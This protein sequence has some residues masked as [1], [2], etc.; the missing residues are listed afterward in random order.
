MRAYADQMVH[1]RKA[2]ANTQSRNDMLDAMLHGTDPDT[3]EKLT[4]ANLVAYAIYFLAKNPEAATKA[5]EEINAVV[6]DEAFA[7][8]HLKQLHYVEACLRESI[9]LSATAPGFNIEPIPSGSDDHT[10]VL[11]AGGEYQIPHNQTI[12]AILHT[13]NRDPAVFEYP[14]DFRPEQVLGEK[15]DNLPAA[16]QKGFG[17]GKRECIGKAWAWQ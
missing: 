12:I 3:A 2:N 10:P 1:N 13:V 8:H 7:L 6:G 15:W 17:N 5:R 4:A 14:E 16:A 9:R 11:L